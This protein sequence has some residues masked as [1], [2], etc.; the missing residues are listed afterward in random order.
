MGE[1]GEKRG[2]KD[3]FLYLLLLPPLNM[4]FRFGILSVQIKGNE[5]GEGDDILV[6]RC[7]QPRIEWLQNNFMAYCIACCV[8]TSTA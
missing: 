8:T 7:E 4:V 6:G 1:K 3:L 2:R 5:Y